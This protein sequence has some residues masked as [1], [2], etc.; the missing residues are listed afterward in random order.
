[1]V[2]INHKCSAAGTTP[3]AA[4]CAGCGAPRCCTLPF[5]HWYWHAAPSAGACW[6]AASRCCWQ[7]A[8][9]PWR[10]TAAGSPHWSGTSG[11]LL[12]ARSC[13]ASECSSGTVLCQRLYR[14]QYQIMAAGCA[15]LR[16]HDQSVAVLQ[17]GRAATLRL[18]NVHVLCACGYGALQ[19][20]APPRV[21]RH[22]AKQTHPAVLRG[23]C[24]LS[25]AC[26]LHLQLPSPLQGKDENPRRHMLQSMA[27]VAAPTTDGTL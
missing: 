17:L 11:R 19:R 3:Q 5:W 1:M 7:R 16:G 12:V 4:P 20:A 26:H 25:A 6:S 15:T 24:S 22:S 23:Q 8:R 9:R 27:P 2:P 18:C 10:W 13:M 14:Y 21:R